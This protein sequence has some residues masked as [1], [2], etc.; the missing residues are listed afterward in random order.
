M[1]CFSI[2]KQINQA[3][4]YFKHVFNCNINNSDVE[5]LLEY[6]VI[7][8]VPVFHVLYIIIIFS[9]HTFSKKILPISHLPLKWKRQQITF[10][11]DPFLRQVLYVPMSKH[12]Y[13]FD[14]P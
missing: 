8:I 3:E 6:H 1:F 14:H 4:L 13:G 5:H 10:L 12:K 9:L 2:L 7:K 11:A